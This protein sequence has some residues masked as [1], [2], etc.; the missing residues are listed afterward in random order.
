MLITLIYLE[1]G[2]KVCNDVLV[3]HSIVYNIVDILIS[4]TLYILHISPNKHILTT[5]Q[6]FQGK[7]LFQLIP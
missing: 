6:K 1:R 5:T 2:F 4:Y 7:L 3:L